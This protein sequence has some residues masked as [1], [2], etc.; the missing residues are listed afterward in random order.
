VSEV[1]WIILR[2]ASSRTLALQ[3]SLA[4]VGFEV[5]TPVDTVQRRSR[6]GE[7]PEAVQA[8]LTPRYVFANSDHLVELLALSRS[9]A[10]NYRV[11]D[12]EKRKMVTKGHATFTVFMHLGKPG[13]IHERQLAP[14]RSIERKRKPKPVAREFSAGERVRLTD[15]GFEGLWA[16]VQQSRKNYTRVVIDNWLIPV[17]FPTWTLHPPVDSNGGVKVD[18]CKSEQASS[19]KAA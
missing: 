9:P 3:A 8:P 10:R 13:M 16:T 15:A 18:A 5:W 7:K 6:E 19:A 11:W 1:H 4:E 12:S 17:D 2:T 14:L